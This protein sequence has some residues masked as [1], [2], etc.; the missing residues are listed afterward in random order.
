MSDGCSADVR[1]KSVPI[2]HTSAADHLTLDL[3]NGSDK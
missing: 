2:V 3:A 1:R